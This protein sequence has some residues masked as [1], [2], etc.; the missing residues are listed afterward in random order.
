MRHAWLLLLIAGC[1]KRAP[2]G[3]VLRALPSCETNGKSVRA[4]PL[5]DAVTPCLRLLAQEPADSSRSLLGLSTNEQGR[6]TRVCLVGSSQ[7]S[8]SR[9]LNCVADQLERAAPAL[10]ANQRELVWTLN[11]SY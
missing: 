7:D 5:E 11:V 9:F 6:V 1:V 10:P 8:D 2:D 4:R 3:T